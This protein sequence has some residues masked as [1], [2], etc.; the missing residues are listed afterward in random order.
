MITT[1]SSALT[2]GTYYGGI[3]IGVA[4]GSNC[5]NGGASC[6]AVAGSTTAIQS[7]QPTK[8]TLSA[9]IGDA[10]VTGVTTTIQVTPSGEIGPTDV[11]AIDDEEMKVTGVSGTTISVTRE[12]NGTEDAA[13]TSGTEVKDVVTTPNGTTYNPVET[14][15]QQPQSRLGVGHIADRP[16]ERGPQQQRDQGRRCHSDRR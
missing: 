1:G 11:I 10:D 3:C 9:G 14:Q 2:P 6:K 16:G 4:S 12:W 5:G 8:V 7:Y 15:Q 13:H